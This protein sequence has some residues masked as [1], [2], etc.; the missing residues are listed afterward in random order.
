MKR[1]ERPLLIM[2]DGR[3]YAY[4]PQPDITVYEL[5]LIA[6]VFAFRHKSIMRPF[7]DR[8]PVE[9]KRHFEELEPEPEPEQQ[10]IKKRRWFDRLLRV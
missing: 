8:L 6:P 7:F 5:A 4:D 10:P 1:G 3:R 9:A 2:G